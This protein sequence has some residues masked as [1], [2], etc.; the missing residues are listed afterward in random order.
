MAISDSSI[1]KAYDLWIDN[2]S[3]SSSSSASMPKRAGGRE[4]TLQAAK[5]LESLM[6]GAKGNRLVEL[7]QRVR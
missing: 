1:S 3:S 5:E 2:L 4:E 7:L 6:H